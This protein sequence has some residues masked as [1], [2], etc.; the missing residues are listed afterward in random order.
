MER[1]LPGDPSVEPHFLDKL[2]VEHINRYH[3]AVPY[4]RGK[5]VLDVGCGVGYGSAFLASKGASEVIGIDRS[6]EAIQ[7]ANKHYKKARTRFSVRDCTKLL[8][9]RSS[10]DVVVCLELIEHVKDFRAVMREIRRVLKPRGLLL[11]STPRFRGQ[12]ITEFHV[13]EFLYEEFRDLVRKHFKHIRVYLQ[14]PCYVNLIEPLQSQKDRLKDVRALRLASFDTSSTDKFVL[15]ASQRRLPSRQPTYLTLADDDYI[16]YL[17][18]EREILKNDW[19]EK[20]HL[21]QDLKKRL[22]SLKSQVSSK[23]HEV[24]ELRHSEQVV[25]NDFLKLQAEKE[26][27]YSAL[28]DK[29]LLQKSELEKLLADRDR[30]LRAL[31]EANEVAHQDF[32]RIQHE[33]ERLKAFLHETSA[34][35]ASKEKEL[36]ASQQSAKDLIVQRAELEQKLQKAQ[37]IQAELEAC[38]KQDEQ[39]F[40]HLQQEKERDYGELKERYCAEMNEILSS[41][42]EIGADA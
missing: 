5:R 27:E 39:G 23:Q 2:Y 10:F 37:R 25:R 36:E 3:V 38:I 42:T 29:L 13:H 1:I 30:R 28:K 16:V 17:E 4:I 41:L 33:N 19:K 32:T 35:L 22:A 15:F 31:A 18:K 6:V 26:R 20:E 12:L 8:Y 21:I 9:S 24:D 7:H 11:I 14:N 34:Q 40:L